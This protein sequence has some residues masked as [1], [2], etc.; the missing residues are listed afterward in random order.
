M[1]GNLIHSQ[2]EEA[3]GLFKDSGVDIYLLKKI[4]VGRH[5]LKISMDDSVRKEGFEYSF[6]QEILIEPA[7]ILLVNFLPERGFALK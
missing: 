2:T 3:P 6:E 4:P 1:D 5:H 7:Q